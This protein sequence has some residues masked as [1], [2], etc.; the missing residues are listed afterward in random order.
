M[1]LLPLPSP[2]NVVVLLTASRRSQSAPPRPTNQQVSLA[3]RYLF[4]SPVSFSRRLEFYHAY[5]S[6][7]F[8]EH[9]HTRLTN[10]SGSG[11]RRK[12][13][14]EM[15][16]THEVYMSGH[17]HCSSGSSMD[18][19]AANEA[20]MRVYH[21]RRGARRSIFRFFTAADKISFFKGNV[22]TREYELEKEYHPIRDAHRIHAYLVQ[23][24]RRDWL[25]RY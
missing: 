16:G 25:A 14:L 20:Y 9:L 18:S 5:F 2:T 10:D 22:N 23:A 3:L 12:I 8:A 24:L 7:R 17:V 19:V 21:A 11:R 13:H 1:H 15:R 4:Y 6:D